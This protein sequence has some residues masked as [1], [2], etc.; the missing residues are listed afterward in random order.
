[1]ELLEWTRQVSQHRY[2][3]LEINWEKLELVLDEQQGDFVKRL[4][5]EYPCLSEDDIRIIMLLRIGI[6]HSQIALMEN[7]TLKSFR[8]RR[9]R[10]K[11]KM[12]L[13][14]PSFTRFILELYRDNLA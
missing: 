3:P 8:M 14:C 11:K 13:D 7:I 9:W 1:M 10:I 12:G 6:S 2:C 4:R 5:R